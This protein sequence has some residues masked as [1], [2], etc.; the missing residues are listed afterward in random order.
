V[1]ASKKR[2]AEIA[3]PKVTEVEEETPSTP[4]T[5]KV[6]EI[7]EGNDR[8]STYQAAKPSRIVTN[9]AF[10]EEG[11]ASN[12]KEGGWAEKAKNRYCN[13]SH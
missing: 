5:A 11:R 6:A 3:E 13:A 1:A 10:T 7:F 9:K 2:K 12:Y 8:I 4:P